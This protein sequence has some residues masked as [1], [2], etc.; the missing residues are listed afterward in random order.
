MIMRK[1]VILP[2]VA[3]LAL[4]ASCATDRKDTSLHDGSVWHDGNEIYI[5]EDSTSFWQLYGGTLHEGGFEMKLAKDGKWMLPTIVDNQPKDSIAGTWQLSGDTLR[6]I[7][8]D[9][10][11]QSL[12]CVK[13]L[14]VLSRGDMP[15]KAL[16][17]LDSV[18]QMNVFRQLEGKYADNDG[19]TWIFSGNT[20][21]RMGLKVKEKY[22][23]GKSLDMNDSVIFTGDIAYAYSITQHGINLY[24]AKYLDS[25]SVWEYDKK[26]K[27]VVVLVRK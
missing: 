11:A 4:F 21:Q 14:I 2:V 15:K 3:L 23:V 7:G 10:H 22:A 13:G 17:A 26:D 8:R 24:K 19:N 16:P 20:M 27:P 25:E 9:K 12:F 18:Q 1:N 5:V 6:L